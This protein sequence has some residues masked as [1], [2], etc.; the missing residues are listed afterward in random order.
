MQKLSSVIIDIFVVV[1]EILYCF[2]INS[3]LCICVQ[4]RE[5]VFPTCEIRMRDVTGE[6]SAGSGW[7]YVLI[8]KYVTGTGRR[9]VRVLTVTR[10][11]TRAIA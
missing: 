2:I 6:V 1:V 5:V 4:V 11:L 9:S 8:S 10:P 7:F 3:C